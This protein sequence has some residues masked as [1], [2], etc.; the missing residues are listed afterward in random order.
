ME[1]IKGG[2]A[3]NFIVD[4]TKLVVDERARPPFPIDV[5]I[6]EE[7]TNLVLTLDNVMVYQ[8]E[9]PIRIM[10]EINRTQNQR[11]GSLVINGS[12]WYAVTIDIDRLPMCESQWISDAYAAVFKAL[13][14]KKINSAGI[15]ILGS[16]HANIPIEKTTKLFLDSFR[17]VKIK[18]L[19]YVWLCVSQDKVQMA[20]KHILE[21]LR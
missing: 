1:L 16:T 13:A 10:T 6:F 2:G 21:Y 11:P 12:S 8:E 19:K 4:G 15:Q 3:K 5:M 14:K 9:H 18:Y 20:R 7:D 17:Y